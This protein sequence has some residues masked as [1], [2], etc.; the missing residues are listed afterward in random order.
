MQYST[1]IRKQRHKL[2][3]IWS[4]KNDDKR[5][6]NE[7]SKFLSKLFDHCPKITTK[8][9]N[10]APWCPRSKWVG[11]CSLGT[12]RDT[13]KPTQQTKTKTEL[14]W[15]NRERNSSTLATHIG[16][17]RELHRTCLVST[18]SKNLLNL[19]QSVHTGPDTSGMLNSTKRPLEKNRKPYQM[20]S[21]NC[22]IWDI[23][24]RHLE[25]SPPNLSFKLESLTYRTCPKFTPD[26]SG[27]YEQISGKFDSKLETRP[28]Q[29]GSTWNFAGIFLGVLRRYLQSISTQ[30]P[31]NFKQSQ[32]PSRRVGFSQN[33]S[34][35]WIFV[36]EL[37]VPKPLG[38]ND[39]QMSLHVLNQLKSPQR[40]RFKETTK[41]K[42]R[43]IPG[44]EEHQNQIKTK[45]TQILKLEGQEEVKAS[46]PT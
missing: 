11:G 35:E 17:V 41:I 15:T 24:S 27:M 38:G 43:G 13:T 6:V 4:T 3:K 29:L 44:E 5:G 26:M 33:S 28:N 30:N 31:T 23:A 45:S 1:Y 42:R 37:Y 16:P 19:A 12:Q 20:V 36:L 14:K 22:E 2:G 10:Q 39:S 32:N 46:I 25:V 21:K 8:H 9:A 34:K 40:L 7:S 18:I